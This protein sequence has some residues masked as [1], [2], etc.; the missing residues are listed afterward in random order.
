MPFDYEIGHDQ[1]DEDKKKEIDAQ[2]ESGWGIER[3]PEPAP[4]H[5]PPAGDHGEGGYTTTGSGGNVSGGT[6]APTPVHTPA[7]DTDSG[8]GGYTTTGS[9]GNV[10]GGTPVQSPSGGSK[11]A[12]DRARERWEQR[13]KE[14]REREAEAE[15]RRQ[16]R[17][18]QDDGNDGASVDDDD[19]D[20]EW[21]ERW[22]APSVPVSSQPPSTSSSPP[23]DDGE[24]GYRYEPSP[25]PARPVEPSPSA[26]T[27]EIAQGNTDARERVAG[28][29][30]GSPARVATPVA[31]TPA[32]VPTNPTAAVTREPAFMSGDEDA[33]VRETQTVAEAREE[34]EN[35]RDIYD[36]ADPLAV[37]HHGV[38]ETRLE[39]QSAENELNRAN[40]AYQDFVDAGPPPDVISKKKQAQDRY[41]RYKALTDRYAGID[42]LPEDEYNQMLRDFEAADVLLRE[43]QELDTDANNLLIAHQDDMQTRYDNVV[44]TG[45][46]AQGAHNDLRGAYGDFKGRQA[47]QQREN[48]LGTLNQNWAQ[49]YEFMGAD[50]EKV[51]RDELLALVRRNDDLA[52]RQARVNQYKLFEQR[53]NPPSAPPTA[54]TEPQ[55]DEYQKHIQEGGVDRLTELEGSVARNQSEIA[56]I[57]D[58][59]EREYAEYADIPWDNTNLFGFLGKESDA[60]RMARINREK[61]E[62]LAKLRTDVASEQ[63]RLGTADRKA[64]EM[65]GVITSPEETERQRRIINVEM[66]LADAQAKV[67]NANNPIT[68][69]AWESV[70]WKWRRELAD[71]N[72]KSNFARELA[73]DKSLTY[74]METGRYVPDTGAG[75]AFRSTFGAARMAGDDVIQPIVARIDKF[76]SPEGSP[77]AAYAYHNFDLSMVP[78]PFT[79]ASP[80]PAMGYAK[81]VFNFWRNQD[82][83]KDPYAE[84]ATPLSFRTGGAPAQG[85]AY[86]GA[87]IEGASG[88]GGQQEEVLTAAYRQAGMRP[89]AHLVGEPTPF[90]ALVKERQRAI[91]KEGIPLGE[92]AQEVTGP[93]GN[94]GEFFTGWD[95]KEEFASAAM[96]TFGL[97]APKTAMPLRLRQWIDSNKT[98]GNV[99]NIPQNTSQGGGPGSVTWTSPEFW[100]RKDGQLVTPSVSSWQTSPGS[101]IVFPQAPGNVTPLPGVPAPPP[102]NNVTSIW[103]TT[104]SGI[105]FPTPPGR[106]G[107][108]RASQTGS[109]TN[110]GGPVSIFQRPNPTAP[111]NI[112]A[113]WQGDPAILGNLAIV[114]AQRPTML[115]E[116]IA[117]PTPITQPVA[118][119]QA[120]PAETPQAQPAE[121]PAQIAQPI[122]QPAQAPMQI[123]QPIET[124]QVAAAAP[125]IVPIQVPAPPAPSP[126]IDP[127]VPEPAPVQQPIQ[128]PVQQPIEIAKP[129]DWTQPRHVPVDIPQ[130]I[131]IPPTWT[132]PG[133]KI[134]V[135]IPPP[136]KQPGLD[137]PPLKKG[138]IDLGGGME[139]PEPTP[140]PGIEK[141]PEDKGTGGETPKK[142]KTPRPRLR[143]NPKDKPQQKPQKDGDKDNAYIAEI[144]WNE[145]TTQYTLDMHTGKKSAAPAL[146]TGMAAHE[147]LRVS[148]RSKEPPQDRVIDLPGV[149]DARVSR[150]TIQKIALPSNYGTDFIKKQPS[151][152]KSKS[153]LTARTSSPS[154]RASRPASGGRRAR[155][156]MFKAMVR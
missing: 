103:S 49:L 114:P 123:A 136:G 14:R 72:D 15:R 40:A 29:N 23:D 3:P 82:P 28:G 37:G 54:P 108:S 90:W 91:N 33:Y 36:R 4:V 126:I 64:K 151:E 139:Q 122:E 16:E 110:A 75:S 43:A 48:Q 8:E 154:R 30:F 128:Q 86:M 73:V 111:S 62:Q 35:V 100:G 142:K 1:S 60:E 79:G 85:F 53:L 74:D 71:L 117:E 101:N 124:P 27:R 148:R 39:F 68:R 147:T 6:P 97:G 47:A 155:G 77:T 150:F 106:G 24:G 13:E 120:Q 42:S 19:D 11:T 84:P 67:D 121:T 50:P 140:P 9:G 115:P 57:E 58:M 32:R 94:V 102:I 127:F 152:K 146:P 41:D 12:A 46:R 20:D 105:T 59:S 21:K 81:D 2:L 80:V 25:A 113:G 17:R 10:S 119:Q 61:D 145:G 112:V 133:W 31:G 132:T 87:I 143:L 107:G 18:N 56:K 5:T 70:A 89:D 22:S 38:V 109:P 99:T 156:K 125:A 104:P 63:Y 34:I 78:N 95:T 144:K 98:P 51:S 141:V 135:K 92:W 45:D 52:A 93:V 137:D 65:L 118:I 149:I 153:R 116:P 26:P 134:P 44:A 66:Q 83:N 55:L 76:A 96:D 138:E 129:I 88:M 69:A 130:P 131:R 7:H